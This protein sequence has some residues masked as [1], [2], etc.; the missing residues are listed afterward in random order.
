M[1]TRKEFD[2]ALGEAP[3]DK[4]FCADNTSALGEAPREE[5]VTECAE[6]L[7]EETFGQDDPENSVI[8]PL[9]EE[10]FVADPGRKGIPWT[11]WVREEALV[12]DLGRKGIPWTSWVRSDQMTSIRK[13]MHASRTSLGSTKLIQ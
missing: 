7:L 12:A 6:A 2:S 8:Q 10:A 1:A 9:S 5:S 3:N 4:N 13:Q 11:S